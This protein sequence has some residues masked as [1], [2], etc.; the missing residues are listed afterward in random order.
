[1][2]ALTSTIEEAPKDSFDSVLKKLVNVDRI[3]EPAEGEVKLTMLKKEEAKKHVKKGHSQPLPPVGTGMVGGN[4][5]LSQI[6]TV[7]PVSLDFVLCSIITSKT[8]D[9]FRIP[10]RRHS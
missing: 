3:D 7:R 5:T 1:M 10:G 4:A 2:H 9:V 6:K 8:H